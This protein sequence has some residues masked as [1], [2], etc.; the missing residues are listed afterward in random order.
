MKAILGPHRLGKAGCGPADLVK[1]GRTPRDTGS[2]S[3][4][5]GGPLADEKRCLV[6]GVGSGVS[7]FPFGLYSRD[8]RWLQSDGT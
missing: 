1:L 3:V 8:R 6:C 5:Q 4:R 2:V 7:S